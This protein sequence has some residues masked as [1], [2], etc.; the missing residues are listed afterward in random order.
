MLGEKISMKDDCGK[1][2]Y[3]TKE[4]VVIVGLTKKQAK[5][6][7][8]THKINGIFHIKEDTYSA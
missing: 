8:Q 4:V 2:F 7:V 6:Y 5:D 3:I 1:K